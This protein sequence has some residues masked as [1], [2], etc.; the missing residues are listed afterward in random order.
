[1]EPI[2]LWDPGLSGLQPELHTPPFQ[3]ENYPPA[4]LIGL[5]IHFSQGRFSGQTIRAELREIQRPPFGRRFGSADRRV[6]NDPPVV[7]LRLFY[8]HNSGTDKEWS[9]EIQN[10]DSIPLDGLICMVDLFEV[11]EN[12]TLHSQQNPSPCLRTETDSFYPAGAANAAAFIPFP[13]VQSSVGVTPHE[14]PFDALV[15]V[16]GYAVTER[17]KRTTFLFGTK[18]VEP[19][20]IAFPDQGNDRNFLVFTFSDLAVRLDG[21]F[22]LRYRFFDLF[23]NPTGQNASS[24]VQAECYGGPFRVYSTRDAPALP[25]STVLTK[26]L[27]KQGVRVNS[28]PVPRPSRRRTSDIKYSTPFSGSQQDG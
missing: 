22:I 5:P 28:R 3:G 9:E 10:Y 18:F 16:N 7:L 4:N 24:T 17:S 6:L 21:Y 26:D 11:P 20:K 23:S 15:L 27:V 14:V 25:A 2:S 8:V 13:G 19:H 1:M 12:I